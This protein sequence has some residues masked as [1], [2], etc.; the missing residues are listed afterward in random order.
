MPVLD[1]VLAV[2]ILINVL[3]AGVVGFVAS[4]W[5]SF[6]L[7]WPALAGV[8][9]GFVRIWDQFLS[10]SS[11]FE[12]RFAVFCD[13]LGDYL[14]G[15]L[16]VVLDYMEKAFQPAPEDR[17]R[18]LRR[19]P[20]RRVSAWD[21]QHGVGALQQRTCAICLEDWTYAE[22]IRELPTCGHAFHARCADD[23]LA[24][25]RR[26]PTCRARVLDA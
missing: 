21:M 15:I 23:W 5:R 8:L 26:C 12:V 10:S 24:M 3:A 17:A 22:Q 4:A 6:E 14:E 19:L 18:R 16:Q 9:L 7:G 25:Q 1:A 20:L 13:Q 2:F 11:R